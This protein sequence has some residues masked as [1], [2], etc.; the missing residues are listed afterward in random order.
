MRHLAIAAIILVAAC[1]RGTE[2]AREL[3]ADLPAYD[4]TAAFDL[5][6]TQVAFGPSPCSASSTR[7][8]AARC[9]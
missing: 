4:A 1:D 2:G 9:R 7:A 6:E 8:R 5:I 3:P